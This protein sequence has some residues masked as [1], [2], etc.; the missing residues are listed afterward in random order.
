MKSQL[1]WN[2][3]TS[4]RL[5]TSQSFEKNQL[6]TK[7]TD[8]WQSI[9]AYLS[10]SSE[11]RVWQTH[12]AGEVAWSAYDPTTKASIDRV[13]AQELRV[14]LEERHYQNAY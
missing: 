8:L 13:S 4:S 11:P 2:D 9:L 1:N 7:L 12:E 3:V 5:T 10:S 14:W 6:S